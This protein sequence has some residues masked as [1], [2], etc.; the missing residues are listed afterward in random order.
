MTLAHQG[1][2][3]PGRIKTALTLAVVAVCALVW[4]APLSADPPPWAPAWGFRGQGKGKGKNKFRHV[5]KRPFDLNLG[6]CNRELLGSVL[7]GAG[8]GLL[9]AQIGDGKGQL[10]AVAGGALLGFLI[11]GSVGRTMDE[12][13]QN[14]VGQ[15]LEHADD[16]QKI[17]W[18]NP[19]SGAQYKIVPTKTVQ[20][21]DGRYCREYNTT[22]VIG[23]RTQEVHGT[24]CRQPD[25]A[26]KLQN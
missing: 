20:R 11:G 4:S 17:T 2:S 18:K 13:D 8:G 15:A 14:C 21:S 5:Y 19:E 24:A 1:K 16:G 23:G 25:G 3:Q 9:G 22:A 7:G 10:A 26:W 12:V 6:R